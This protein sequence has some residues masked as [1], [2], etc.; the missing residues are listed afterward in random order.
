MVDFTQVQGSKKLHMRV[1][2]SDAKLVALTGI[3]NHR[4]IL[5]HLGDSAHIAIDTTLKLDIVATLGML[6]TFHEI[7]LC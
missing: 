2:L 5:L 1:L 7:P 3:T 6:E 4:C